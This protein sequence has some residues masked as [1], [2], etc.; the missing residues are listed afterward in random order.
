MKW[1]KYLEEK[2]LV[3]KNSNSIFAENSLVI[4]ESPRAKAKLK[5]PEQLVSLLGDSYL[6]VGDPSHVPAGK[7][8]QEALEYHKVWRSCLQAR[9]WPCIQM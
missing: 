7:Y 5:S 1:F 6:A 4:I 3:E 9:S 8:A 2:K